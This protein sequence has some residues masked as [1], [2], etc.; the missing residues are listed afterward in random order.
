M[1]ADH[2]NRSD[3]ARKWTEAMLNMGDQD[4]LHVIN[5]GLPDQGTLLSAA[6][7]NY[8][9]TGDA[10]WLTK[11]APTLVKMCQWARNARAK[12]KRPNRGQVIHA[13]G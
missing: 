7:H 6:A 2:L 5:F 13:T 10:K 12:A 11:H 1:L 9:V 8:R 3:E 4:G